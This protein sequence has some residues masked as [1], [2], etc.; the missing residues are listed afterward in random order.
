L[1]DQ[2][3]QDETV[4]DDGEF[5]TGKL[6]CAFGFIIAALA[7]LSLPLSRIWLPVDMM[8]H[9]SLHYM[10]AGGAFL[11]GFLMPKWHL[12][13]AII[14]ILA[15]VAG[16]GW[17]AK[18]NNPVAEIAATA[19]HKNLRVMTFNTWLSNSDW[20]AVANEIISKDP[21]IVTMLE[22]GN[23][24]TPLLKALKARY[25]YQIDCH[26]LS[27]CH[28]AILS[29]YKIVKSRIQTRWKGPPFA[30]ITFGRELGH[31]SV[32]AVHTIRPPHYRAHYRQINALA[33]AVNSVK[34]IKLVM[35]DFNSTPY[36]RTL[37]RF[38]TR[39][40]L[41]RITSKPSWPSRV[42]GLPQ[43]AIDHIFVSPQIKVARP[44][45]LGAN[46]G[47]DHYP[48]NAVVTVPVK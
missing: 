11:S 41:N 12:R 20:K 32:F 38:A 14:L 25:P 8:T 6:L 18:N 33:G 47:S 13:T 9:F 37:R 44:H 16:I 48:V 29:R 36:S 27:Y 2:A 21:D 28:M 22:F 45:Y 26:K 35:G 17:M 39:T 23:E 31:L 24:K 7:M 43:V 34:G 4:A 5:P 15:G 3:P 46:A 30:H 19:N 10:I 1:T 40:G 42:A